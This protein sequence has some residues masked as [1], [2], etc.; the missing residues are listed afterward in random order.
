M[1]INRI[2]SIVVL[3]LQNEMISA[4]ELAK[5][6]GVATR[7][8]HRDVET[9]SR[10][11]IPLVTST[12][13]NGGIGIAGEFK[14]ARNIT[15]ASDMA[16][17]AIGLIDEY[18]GLADIESYILAKHKI[19][20]R[21]RERQKLVGKSAVIKV[22]LRFDAAY[23]SDMEREYS[24]NIVS[25]GEDGFFEAYI[26]I[27]AAEKEYRRLLSIGD[28]CECIDPLHVRNFIAEKIGGIV[29]NY[30]RF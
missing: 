20:A 1:K 21:E 13:P 27:E 8:I 28:I 14:T 5:I 25:L 9:I 22:T 17:V 11:G 26:Y 12:G 3:M 6:F 24:L 15:P 23:K 10:A 29:K 16:S 2:L 19:E 18:P 7:T 30:T 4:P